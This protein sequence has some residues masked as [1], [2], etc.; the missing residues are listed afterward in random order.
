[1]TAS[2]TPD[3][4]AW[5]HELA[6]LL[7]KALHGVAPGPICA[8][9]AAALDATAAA[10]VHT[11]LLQTTVH[12]CEAHAHTSPPAQLAVVM[13]A[14]NGLDAAQARTLLARVRDFIAPRI[15]VVATAHCALDRLA[16]LAIG[17]EVLGI[18]ATENMAIFHFDLS[19]YKQ[20]PD[21]LNARHW[22]HPERWKP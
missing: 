21:W 1:M 12:L 10:L 3:S 22:A 18:D 5:R 20:V 15:V 17:F 14:L 4:F 7:V 16:F 13:D 8:L 6:T 9:D 2:Q 11:G 19:T